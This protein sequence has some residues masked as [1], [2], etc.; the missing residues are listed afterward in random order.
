MKKLLWMSV[1]L[2]LT[3][4][5]ASCSRG[6][7]SENTPQATVDGKPDDRNSSASGLTP[8]DIVGYERNWDENPAVVRVHDTSKTLYALRG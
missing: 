7:E 8:C 3:L 4:L 5:C 6:G 2:N 1:A